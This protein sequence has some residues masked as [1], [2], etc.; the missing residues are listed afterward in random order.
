MKNH[1]N[2]LNVRIDEKE[3]DLFFRSRMTKIINTK[4]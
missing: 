2:E 1:S 4:A 3:H